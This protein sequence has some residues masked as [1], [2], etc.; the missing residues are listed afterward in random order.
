MAPYNTSCP[1]IAMSAVYDW[2]SEVLPFNTQQ[3]TE[4]LTRFIYESG[5]DNADFVGPTLGVSSED[6]DPP[7]SKTELTYTFS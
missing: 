6:G 3:I 1:G 5:W 4:G 2:E 7:T